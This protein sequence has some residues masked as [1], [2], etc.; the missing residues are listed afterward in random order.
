M[1]NNFLYLIGIP[2]A[3][4]TSLIKA[5]LSGLKPTVLTKPFAHLQYVNAI[6][7]G[8]NRD[9]FSGTDA[10]PLNVQPIVLQWLIDNRPENV[11]AEG[12]RL[13]NASFF[14]AL[15][16]LGYRL[17]VCLLDTSSPLAA[18]RRRQRGS[19]QNATWIKGRETKVAALAPYVTMKLDGQLPTNDL[20]R[21]LRAHPVIQSCYG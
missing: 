7:L 6:Q 14:N 18:Q 10:L 4:K 16:A 1:V 8:A 21:Q 20:A 11:L 13:G 2:G 19:R 17:D 3:G 5:T 12:D 15:Y 9:E